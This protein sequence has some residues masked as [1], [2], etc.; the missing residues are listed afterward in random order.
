MLTS[1]STTSVGADKQSVD[2]S[3]T[4]TKNVPAAIGVSNGVTVGSILPGKNVSSYHSYSK[5]GGAM[6]APD[7]AGPPPME[8]LVTSALPSPIHVVGSILSTVMMF[9]KLKLKSMVT[10]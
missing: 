7:N 8:M 4:R 1:S 2:R 3:F 5:L 10:V 6:A 9:G